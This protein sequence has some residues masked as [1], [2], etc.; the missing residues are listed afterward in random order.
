MISVLNCASAAVRALE[1][2]ADTGATINL[3]DDQL[4]THA[5]YFRRC[6]S[7]GAPLGHMVP[8]PWWV[9]S[10]A[11][12]ALQIAN[13]HL[14]GGRMT[15]PEILDHRRQQVRWK[16]LRYPNDRARTML[17]W[18]PQ[19]SVDATIASIVAHAGGRQ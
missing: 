2:P 1:H 19:H 14:F 18:Q 11:G 15:L 13:R 9:V 5:E 17:D 12:A 4:P 8:V 3:V 10:G 16:P 7:A 6:R